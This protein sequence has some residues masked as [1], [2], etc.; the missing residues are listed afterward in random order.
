MV[1]CIRNYGQVYF[2]YQI[3]VVDNKYHKTKK[4]KNEVIGDASK[5]NCYYNL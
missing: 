3:Y 1:K 2:H 4:V 5:M